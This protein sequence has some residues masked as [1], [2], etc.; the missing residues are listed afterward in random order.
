M[1]FCRGFVKPPAPRSVTFAF[2][3]ARGTMP[4]HWRSLLRVRSLTVDLTQSVPSAVA[5]GALRDEIE[6]ILTTAGL[7]NHFKVI[8]SAENVERGKPEP[9][10]FLKALAALNQ[11]NSNRDPIDASECVVIGRPQRRYQ[12][13]ATRHEVSGGNQLPSARTLKRSQRRR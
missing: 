6:A 1:N 10:V 5:S 4:E 8:I 3:S 12:R 9:D 2:G 11:Q 13:R 7:L